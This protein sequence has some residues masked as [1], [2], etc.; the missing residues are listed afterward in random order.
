MF[1]GGEMAANLNQIPRA[2]KRDIARA[3]LKNLRARAKKGIKEPALDEYIDELDDIDKALDRHVAGN[4]VADAQRTA[5]L[6]R[7]DAADDQVD[8]LYRHVESYALVEARRRTGP[9][10]ALALALH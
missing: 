9:N 2:E 3:V 1:G 5:R 6:A 10:I 8:P 7:L 4:V